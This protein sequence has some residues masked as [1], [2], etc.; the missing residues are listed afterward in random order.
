MLIMSRLND[1]RFEVEL[2][3]NCRTE[4]LNYSDYNLV[5][6]LCELKGI[7]EHIIELKQQIEVLENC[8]GLNAING[9]NDVLIGQ[10]KQMLAEY[11]E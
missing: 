11:L 8:R 6:R 1:V 2:E 9:S 5:N 3:Q 7:L 10:L 4:G